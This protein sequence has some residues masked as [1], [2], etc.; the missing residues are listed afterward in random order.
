MHGMNNVKCGNTSFEFSK[1]LGVFK[2]AIYC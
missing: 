2:Q 1:Y